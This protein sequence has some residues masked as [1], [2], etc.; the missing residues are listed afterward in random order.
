MGQNQSGHSLEGHSK[1][2]YACSCSEDGLL[3]LSGAQQGTPARPRCPAMCS[4]T[5][6]VGPR[7]PLL[8]QSLQ[9]PGADP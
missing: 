8:D 1:A 2:V 4:G 3:L 6:P 7:S 9:D 5:A